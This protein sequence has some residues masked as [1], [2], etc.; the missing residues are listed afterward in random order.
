MSNIDSLF[1]W[2]AEKGYGFV[3]QESSENDIFVHSRA[4]SDGSVALEEGQTV[5]FDLI[6]SVKGEQAQNVTL[7]NQS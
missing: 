1:R 3:R 7:L 2:I 4:L 6:K 5:E